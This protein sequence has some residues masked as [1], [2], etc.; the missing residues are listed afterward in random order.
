MDYAKFKPFGWGLAVGAIVLLI[1]MF[2]TGWVVTSS[3]AKQK[4]QEQA[5]KAVDKQMAEICLYQFKHADDHQQK[6]KK[7]EEMEYNWDRAEYIRKQGW[8]SMPGEDS[9]SSG[10]ADNCA[11]KI[12]NMYQDSKGS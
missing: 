10:V 7:M 4:A 3:T 8:A 1:L 12:M 9:S 5:E 6:L 11:K 2:S